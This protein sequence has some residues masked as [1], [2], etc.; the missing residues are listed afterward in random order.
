MIISGSFS[1]KSAVKPAMMHLSYL[2]PQT[3]KKKVTRYHFTFPIMVKRSLRHWKKPGSWPTGENP[4]S[5]GCHRFRCTI[6]SKK[7]GFVLALFI[8]SCSNKL[9]K[10]YNDAIQPDSKYPQQEFLPVRWSRYRHCKDPC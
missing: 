9:L 10:H 3:R 1:T 6:P 5:S 7:F 8:Q 2:R 4:E